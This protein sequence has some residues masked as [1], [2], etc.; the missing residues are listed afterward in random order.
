MRI[1]APTTVALRVLCSAAALRSTE[2]KGERVPGLR[3]LEVEDAVCN[4]RLEKRERILTHRTRRAGDG[5]LHVH[6]QAMGAIDVARQA[7]EGE[8]LSPG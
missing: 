6:P 4:G 5:H 2:S 8:S 1:C 7:V 3:I